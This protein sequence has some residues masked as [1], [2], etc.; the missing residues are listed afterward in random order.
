MLQP[1]NPE[2]HSQRRKIL[3]VGAEPSV[4][5]LITT[6]LSTMGL[7]CT[8]VQNMKVIPVLLQREAFDALVMDLG[9]SETDAEQTILRIKEIRPSLG[10]RILAIGN[11]GLDRGML[12]LM[13]RHDMIQ[14]S[15]DGL[16]SQLWASLEELFGSP[17][18]R[19]TSLRSVQ[20]ARM[21]FDS[22][23]R[24]LP[25]G[26]RSLYSEARHLAYQH[27]KTV[28]DLAIELEKRTG[29]TSLAGQVLDGERKARA[30]GLSVL[31]VSGTGTLAR[32]TTNQ[33]GEFHV[34]YE[35][36]EDVS[37]EI[38]VA[39]R[40]WVSIPLGR[41]GWAGKRESSWQGET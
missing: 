35:F 18:S 12:E 10:D 17:R 15:Q 13:E 7:A 39:E 4:Q 29:R 16:L 24:P 25:A 27:R 34:E 38:R 20:V 19:E 26:M 21:I 40:S 8:V 28:I 23:R 5:G 41:M 37:L 36:P 9:R 31:L 22:Y 2:V 11:S 1:K 3:L 33:F 6:F 30:E 14:L 32:T